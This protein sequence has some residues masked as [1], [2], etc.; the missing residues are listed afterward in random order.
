[1]LWNAETTYRITDGNRTVIHTTAL[2]DPAEIL[3][4][5]GILMGR[6]DKLDIQ[7]TG[8]GPVFQV[9]RQQKIT[10]DYYGE[11]TE[12]VSYG[13]RVAQLLQ[14]LELTVREGDRTS[15][16]LTQKTHDGMVLRVYREFRQEQTYTATLPFDTLYCGD[17]TLPVGTQLV[18]IQ[19]KN[20]E[21]MRTAEVTYINGVEASR[22]ILSEQVTVQPVTGVVAIG[23]GQ[24]VTE[25]VPDALPVI[26]NGLIH[27]PTGEVLTYSRV[28]S[29]LATAYCSKGLTATGTKARVGAIAV[30]PEY[31]PYGTR[32]FIISKDGE[33]IY[34]IA[35]A[36]DC[37]SK[38]FI[39]GTRIDLHYDTEYECVQFGARMCWVYILS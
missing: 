15:L 35:T 17:P 11:Q 13:E 37:G 32:M 23:T 14:R 12:A 8:D 30:D 5:A 4:E 7:R 18:L 6:D 26:G 39:Y 38:D 2:E 33:Y 21:V 28:I 25:T 34:G 9:L 29:S 27:L 19:G 36:E 16:P 22:N 1:M 10:V 3:Q 24:Q 31:I 20:G